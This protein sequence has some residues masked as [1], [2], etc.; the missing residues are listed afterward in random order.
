ML[1]SLLPSPL[2]T[3][4]YRLPTIDAHKLTVD[5]VSQ[6]ESLGLWYYALYI[7][8]HPLIADSD[9]TVQ[10]RA[11]DDLLLDSCRWPPESDNAEL[12][13]GC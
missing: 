1:L 9:V 8:Q 10:S 4:D 3:H 11:V 12:E 13:P 7:A 6:L 2:N 5:Y